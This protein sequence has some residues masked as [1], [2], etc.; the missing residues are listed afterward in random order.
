MT[1]KK[2][3]PIVCP[4]CGKPL[5]LGVHVWN[6]ELTCPCGRTFKV[7]DEEVTNAGRRPKRDTRNNKKH[8]KGI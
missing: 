7:K 3:Q 6:V 1:K 4:R 2:K 5:L 8:S